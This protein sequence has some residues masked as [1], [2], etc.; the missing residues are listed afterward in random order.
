MPKLTAAARRKLPRKAF[1]LNGDPDKDERGKTDTDRD[2]DKGSYPIPDT[3]HARMA[4]AMV[5]MHGTP[6]MKAQV[7]AAVRRKFPWIQ[8]GGK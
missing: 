7:K 4:L 5:S 8:Q 1:A 6:E 2:G 3:T